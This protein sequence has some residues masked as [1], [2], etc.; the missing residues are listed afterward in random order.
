MTRNGASEPFVTEPLSNGVRV[1][2]GRADRLLPRGQHTYAISYRTTRQLGFF[3][4]YDEL[5]WNVTGTGWTFAI[6]VAEARIALP[7]AVPFRQTAFY[8]GPEGARGQD[9][10]IVE[11][12]P[13]RIVFRT[14]RPLPPR[15][16]LTVAVAWPKGI[17]AQP[18]PADLARWW[19]AD[20]LP[21]ALG[22]CGF[23]LLFGYYVAAWNLV[24]RDPPR[25]TIIPLFAPPEGMSAAAVRY[26]RRMGFD[27]RCFTAAIVDLGVNGHLRLKGDGDNMVIE[28]RSGGRLLG[29]PEHATHEKLFA[30]NPSLE[31]DR[32][33]HA[34]LGAAKAALRDGLTDAYSGMLFNRNNAWSVVGAIGAILLGIAVAIAAVVTYG[35]QGGVPIVIG[36]VFGMISLAV[37]GGLV[38]AWR[39][40]ARLRPAILF[41]LIVILGI[42]AAVIVVLLGVMTHWVEALA[43]VPP[44]LAA[45][46]AAFAFYLLK[47]PT[48]RGR[49]V[50]DAIEGFRQY[51]GVAEEDRLQFLHPPEKTPQLFEK[52]LPHAIALDVENAWAQRFAGVLAAA[53]A[54]GAAASTW[55]SAVSGSRDPVSLASQLGGAFSDTIAA[56]STAPGSSGG[57]SGGGSSGGGGGGGGGSGW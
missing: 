51:L 48:R 2:I 26:V 56:A 20:N 32:S 21:L 36:M 24:G 15:Q 7:Q 49:R 42:D 43:I 8:T 18:A 46:V 19:F 11:Q 28:R 50:M 13:G 35:E 25:G 34:I 39:S 53:G 55:Y 1:R 23:L 30:R 45:A 6:D 44:M 37:A 38:V 9:A 5:Y 22:G 29:A 40:G 14:T 52:F 33:N 27:D 3:A 47:A 31:L 17:V 57:S 54:A 12:E 10:R 4:D 16:G 41:A